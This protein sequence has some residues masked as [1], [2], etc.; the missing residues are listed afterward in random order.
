MTGNFICAR[1]SFLLAITLKKIIL[2][3]KCKGEKNE[4]IY[5]FSGYRP[6]RGLSSDARRRS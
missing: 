1:T 2:N 5:R 4:E 3:I 6:N